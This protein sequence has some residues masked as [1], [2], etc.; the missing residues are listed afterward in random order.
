MEIEAL[1]L[2]LLV[3]AAL[4]RTELPSASAQVFCRSQFNLANEACSLRPFVPGARRPGLPREQLNETSL[5]TTSDDDD[6]D[7]D[8]GRRSSRHHHRHYSEEED[9]R[10]TACC[11]RIMGLDNSCVCQAT[12]RLPPFMNSIRHTIKLTPIEGCEVTFDCPG[13]LF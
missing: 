12:A 2:A 11:R 13:P 3:S 7:D 8:S 9:P 1:A 5:T 10:D 6:E 4:L